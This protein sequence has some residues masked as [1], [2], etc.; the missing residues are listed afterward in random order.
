MNKYFDEKDADGCLA[1]LAGDLVW[2]T[3]EDMHHFL[4][5]GAV[6]K[7]LQRSIG[8][9]NESRY[10]DLISI[11]SS[12][13]ADN[14]M[15]VAYEV[16]LVSREDERPL[17]LRCSMA[18]CRRGR[19]LEITFLHFSRKTER[20]SSEQLRGFVS[21]LPCGVMILAC[22]DGQREEAV[23]Y[24]DYFARRLRYGEE[25]FARAMAQNPFFMTSEKDR[26]QIR[27]QIG[28]ARKNGGNIT[29]NLRFFR[30]DGNSFYYRMT[31]APAY[32]ADGGTVY[33]CVFQETTGFRLTNDRLQSR[34]DTASGILRQIPEAICAIEYPPQD[35]ERLPEE[36]GKTAADA[37]QDGAGPDVVRGR[38]G[39]TAG[40]GPRV[41]FISRNIPA[42]F[43]VSNS[44]YSKNILRDPFYG[45]EITSITR[46]R[47]LENPVFGKLKGASAG[48][49]SCGIF[50]LRGGNG[51]GGGTLE[52]SRIEDPAVTPAEGQQEG[53]RQVQKEDGVSSGVPEAVSVARRMPE[54]GGEMPRVELVVRRVREKNGTVRMYLFYYDREAQQKELEQRI[55]RA[56]KMGRAGQDQLRADLRRA[57]EGAARRQ[58][59]MQASMKAAQ[60]K[61]EVEITRAENRLLEEK[62]R[63]VLL[64]RQLEE[65]RA[66]RR[67]MSE[68]LEAVK[69]D[70]D[71]RILT[72]KADADRL[73]REAGTARDLLE[74]QLREAQERSRRL[75]SRLRSERT[76]RLLLEEQFREV[77]AAAQNQ[78]AEN[79]SGQDRKDSSPFTS[80]ET[81]AGS[82][83]DPARDWMAG[84]GSLTVFSS[85][86]PET[87]ESSAGEAL[88]G[89][90]SAGTP[91][92]GDVPGGRINHHIAESSLLPG[93]FGETADEEQAFLAEKQIRAREQE[94]AQRRL[95]RIMDRAAKSGDDLSDMLDDFLTA[96]S[97]GRVLLQEQSFSP[98]ACL[99]NI[100][101]YEDFACTEKEITLRLYRDSRLPDCARGFGALLVR[102]L[103]ELLE[104]AIA[105]TRR[106]GLI[107]VHC[108]ADR[109]SG[110]L[111][112]VHF[113]IDDSGAG[114]SP[115]R[116][117]TI[118]E[119]KREAGTDRP[120]HSGLFAAREAAR[121]MGGSV[122]ARSGPGGSRFTLSIA[123]RVQ[124][125]AGDSAVP[126]A[127]QHLNIQG[128]PEGE[129][130]SR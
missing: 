26:E 22:L 122:H 72:G 114:I 55:D 98:V 56:M 69:A 68:E 107:S 19:K 130:I 2:I 42:M 16:N 76:R 123:L 35:G 23:F 25:E 127:G 115:S 46:N 60:E 95:R 101:R 15:T 34:L 3:P 6:L 113:R 106:G 92:A 120:I 17:Y 62:N 91:V 105:S 20:D 74:E 118:F 49:V 31:G 93:V 14:I 99:E 77:R 13:S 8:E 103:C 117:Q 111:V 96:A 125:S 21:N 81:G 83:A 88:T 108:R 64:A 61:H 18:I 38:H 44:A 87:T 63:A 39:G 102:A 29:A 70:A 53:L 45:L 48:P 41:F 71:R 51:T 89:S 121:L 11:K 43:G 126:A 28:Q 112:N 32:Q 1:M 85:I 66:A 80:E 119:V 47:L 59:E 27:D 67:Q 65:A 90:L 94:K 110:G 37:A 58:S 33:Y 7:F 124:D 73:V 40:K 4:S 104:N 109:P 10:V 36:N 86:D 30:R 54:A 12:P 78:T 52:G 9:D 129:R 116:I 97:S 128:R 5:E 82:A 57:K 75:E 50:R 84:S 100:L 79:Q 24:N